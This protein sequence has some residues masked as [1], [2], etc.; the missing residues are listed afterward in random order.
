VLD[1]LL[2][3]GVIFAVNLLPAFGPPTWALLIFLRLNLDVAVVP[4]VLVGA[5]SAAGGRMVLALAA[6]RLR[7]RL[8]TKRVHHLDALR[9]A[10]TG[11][12]A[13][14]VLGLGLFALSPIPSA[15]LFLGA[16]VTGVPLRP[17]T[18][19]FFMGRLVSYSLYVGAA[20][21]AEASLR[22][23]LTQAL[24]SPWAIAVQLL[25]LAAVVGLARIPW[26]D[27]LSRHHRP[28]RGLL[29][30]GRR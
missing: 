11:H 27:V 2:V 8:S 22:P 17:L 3:A 14:T 30:A 1:L 29:S 21:A 16:G 20:T 15:Q 12:R 24:S 5:L 6:R 23:L 25:L 10:A 18:A 19:A 13:G 9:D 7:G 28:R 26:A 4:L